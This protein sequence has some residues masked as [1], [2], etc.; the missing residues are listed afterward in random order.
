[1]DDATL[2]ADFARDKSE[3]AFKEL[4]RRHV[5]MVY[6]VCY[7]QLRDAHWAE[8]VTQA[9]FI[10][11]VRKAASLPSGV[12]LGG[13]LY[14]SAVYACSNAR[15]L[16]RTRSYH[17]K[18]VTP[19]RITTE[20]DLVERA[21][22]EGLLDEGLMELSKAQREVLVLRFFEN[23]PLT[24]VCVSGAVSVCARKSAGFGMRAAAVHGTKRGGGDTAILAG[25]LIE[26]SAKAAPA[27]LAASAATA[28]LGGTRCFRV[29]WP[30]LWDMAR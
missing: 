7:R 27:G 30:S 17:E 21:E 20:P 1:M 26:Q 28:A 12:V 16:K 15:D 9:V 4:V 18:L 23:K 25:V 11:L 10:L 2:L 29:T 8:D 6:S 14:R 19:M 22:L 3:E 13:W 5:G 24:E